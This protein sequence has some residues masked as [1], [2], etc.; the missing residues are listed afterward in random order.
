MNYDKLLNNELV[1]LRILIK[2]S[3]KFLQKTKNMSYENVS[4]VLNIFQ[5]NILNCKSI[6]NQLEF[7][8]SLNIIQK[9]IT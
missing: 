7:S 4:K 6:I 9:F 5:S 8:Y 3:A 1:I 2:N